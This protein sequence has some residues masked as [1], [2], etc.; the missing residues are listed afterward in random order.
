MNRI[1]LLDGSDWAQREESSMGT[2]DK[3]ILA[4]GEKDQISIFD[5]LDQ[6]TA[7]FTIN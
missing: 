2:R 3:E 7:V 5:C 4:P 6:V 1:M